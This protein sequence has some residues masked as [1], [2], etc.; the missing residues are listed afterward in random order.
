[1]VADGFSLNTCIWSHDNRPIDSARFYF[2]LNTTVCAQ[3][4]ITS[5]TFDRRSIVQA[6]EP[7]NLEFNPQ[8]RSLHW[9]PF[10]RI[11]LG[12]FDHLLYNVKVEDAQNGSIVQAVVVKDETFV[13]FA[14]AHSL[15]PYRAYSMS[16]QCKIDDESNP[17]WSDFSAS[18]TVETDPDGRWFLEAI[19]SC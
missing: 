5:Y 1:M 19:E 13:T 2:T 8:N 11:H 12:V 16:V 4:N 6:H 9:K 18:I 15:H 10:R 14:G 17:Y 7:V 3:S